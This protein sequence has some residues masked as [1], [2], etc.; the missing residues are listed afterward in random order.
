MSKNEETGWL[1]LWNLGLLVGLVGLPAMLGFF[2][3]VSIE[4]TSKSPSLPWRLVFAGLG[5]LVG[6]FA[7]WRTLMPKRSRK[8][9]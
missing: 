8:E 4:A 9:N 2:A 1:R 3:G 5:A 7:A 6:A